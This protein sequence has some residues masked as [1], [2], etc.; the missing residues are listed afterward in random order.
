MGLGY[1]RAW[2]GRHE[3]SWIGHWNR[4]GAC[5]S[6]IWWHKPRWM[7]GSIGAWGIRWDR[8]ARPGP[9][10]V[11]WINVNGNITKI[12]GGRR[13]LHDIG[14]RPIKGKGGYRRHTQGWRRCRLPYQLKA[15]KREGSAVLDIE[16]LLKEAYE[17]SKLKV[18]AERKD[19]K[20]P[21][22]GDRVVSSLEA[23]VEKRYRQ[24]WRSQGDLQCPWLVWASNPNEVAL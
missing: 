2:C 1:H 12:G 9:G 15:P 7:G 5:K 6:W 22:D 13:G 17:S 11:A 24:G 3:R 4:V 10:F 14:R 21:E 16:A 18:E 8:T 23:K 19:T 20:E